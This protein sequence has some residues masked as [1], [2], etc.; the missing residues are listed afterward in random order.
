MELSQLFGD[1][2]ICQHEFFVRYKIREDAE[3]W[4]STKLLLR[5]KEIAEQHELNALQQRKTTKQPATAAREQ[6]AV[7]VKSKNKGKNSRSRR[8]SQTGNGK[9]KK[10]NWIRPLFDGRKVR[11]N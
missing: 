9:A 1:L 7:A 6:T 3:L 8:T 11:T 5:N 10:N 2:K 4:S